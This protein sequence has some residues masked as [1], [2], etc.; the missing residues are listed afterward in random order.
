MQIDQTFLDALTAEAKENP[1]LR[2][3]RDLRTSA[4][5]GSQRMLNALEPGT[6]L[7][8]HRHR[9]SAETVVIVRGALREDFYDDAGRVSASFTLRAGGDTVAL[10]IPAGQW[11]SVEALSSGTV[12]FEAKDGAYE[13]LA[14]EDVLTV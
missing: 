7:P 3:A 11:H 14:P 9:K 10:Q 12:I 13:P 6:V 8:I 2:Q 5:D 4:A 1:R